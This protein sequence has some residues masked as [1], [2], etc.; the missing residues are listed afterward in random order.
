MDSLYANARTIVETQ[1]MGVQLASEALTY[2]NRNSRIN[3]QIVVTSD[4]RDIDS[5]L[6][7]RAKH[8]AG[9]SDRLQRLQSR[10]DSEKER[11]LLNAIIE[12]RSDYVTSYKQASDILFD[13]KNTEE[14][15]Q[16]LIQLTFPLLLKYRLGWGDFVRFQADDLDEQL[17]RSAIKYVAVRTRTICLIVL[18]VLL[19]F[20][21]AVVVVHKLVAEIIRRQKTES[22]ILRMNEDLELKVLQ[23]TAAVD[24]SNRDLMAAVAEH[25]EADE[26]R[27]RADQLFRSIAENSADLIA[28]V[29]QSGH[30]IYNNP[31][32]GRLLGYTAEELKNSDSFQQIHPDDRPLVTRA[33]QK[34]V[35]TGVGQIVEYRMRRKDGTYVT[36]ESHS[37][38]IRD[39]RGEIEA[40]VISARD[41]S[42]RRMAMHTEKLSAIGQLAAGVAHELNTPAQYV[43]DNLTFLRDTWTELDAAMAFCL[44]PAHAL[45][46]SDSGSSGGVIFAG[47]PRDWDWLRKEVPK[48]ISQSLEGI[49]RMTKILGAMRR[50]SHSGGGEREEVDLNEALDATITVALHQIKDIADVQTDYQPDLPRVE[51]YCDEL[52]QVFLNLIV[53]AT[54]AIRDTSTQGTGHRGKLTIRTRQIDQDVQIE[55]QDNGSGVPLDVRG[56]VFD[57]FFTTKQVGEGTGQGLAICHEIVVQK[58]HG[59]IWFD[60][61]IDKGTTFFVRIPIRFDSN[62]GDSK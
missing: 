52:N 7:D 16:R 18:S 47:P 36:L 19:A 60:T 8:N 33:A 56:R 55:I 37:S 15:R 22:G 53:N 59:T 26:A 50:F 48:A 12:A 49:R 40:L 44:A 32:Y 6:V 58:H 57:P 54:H 61:E 14:A 31:T 11:E 25:K 38:F 13:Q 23:R 62:T 30:R 20:G 1:W 46:P 34:A 29:D 4:P 43:S 2:S 51:C 17:K 27:S 10:L 24:Q 42:D 41:V 28:V 9:S 21:I 3:M 45:I 39:S 5:I 35:E